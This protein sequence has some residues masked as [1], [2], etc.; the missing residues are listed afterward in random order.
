MLKLLS[1]L[2]NCIRWDVD[3]QAGEWPLISGKTGS[4]VTFDATGAINPTAG[5]GAVAAIWSES[6]R[7]GTAGFSP[8]IVENGKITVIGGGWRGLTSEFD[9]VT[10]GSPLKVKADGKLTDGTAGTDAIVGYC[11]KAAADVVE[12][13]N[14]KDVTTSCIEVVIY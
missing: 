9:S 14:G 11:T 5:D 12:S 13:V 2:N 6:N 3:V 8:D 7:D 4:F 10:V 1:N